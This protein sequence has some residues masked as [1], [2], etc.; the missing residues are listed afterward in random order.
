M[1]SIERYHQM[2]DLGVFDE[3]KVE[4][5]D[6]VLVEKMSKSELH[7]FVVDLLMELL[8]DFTRGSQFWV[9]KKDPITMERS[10]LEP[11]VSVVKGSRS[12]FR[13]AKPRTAQLV[14]EVAIS[15]LSIDRAKAIEYAK[16]GIAEYWIV[17][18]EARQTEVYRFPTGERFTK[19][20]IVPAESILESSA[21]PG[22]SFLLEK[23][24]AD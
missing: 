4:L 15:S 24:L 22:F 23:A 1:I 19:S 18:P 11:D 12:Q 7:L 17:Q 5:L 2:I 9:R 8:L 3:W 14:I 20:I 21:L 13:H 6:G 16:A 10:E